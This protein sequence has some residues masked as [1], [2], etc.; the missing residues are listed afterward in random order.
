MYQT[1]V[2]TCG[3]TYAVYAS[4]DGG[5]QWSLVKRLEGSLGP[6]SVVPSPSGSG[7]WLANASCV[8]PATY[9]WT[10][11]NH[12]ARLTPVA[13]P[14]IAVGGGPLGTTLVPGH[15]APTLITPAKFGFRV[16]RASV[17]CCKS[18]PSAPGRK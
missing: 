3:A 5:A 2:W 8:S 10:S 14:Q 15:P 13:G 11:V 12:W 16:P 7:L 6:I 18:P 1:G 9:L 4:T 17:T